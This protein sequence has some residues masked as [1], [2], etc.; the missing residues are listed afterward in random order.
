[1][2]TAPT[3]PQVT[4]R[5]RGALTRLLRHVSGSIGLFLTLVFVLMAIAG[6]WIAPYDPAAPDYFNLTAGISSEHWLGTDA[7]GRDTLSRVLAGARYSITIGLSA[8]LLGA[9]VGGAW[10]LAAGFFSGWFDTLSMRLVDVL[11]AFPGILLAIGLVTL[12]GPGVGPVVLASAIFGIPVFARLARGSTIGIKEGAYI[13]AATGLGASNNRVML[14]HVL[15]AV[16]QPVLVFAT[17]RSGSTL[18]IASGLS[19]LG[20]GIRAP[21]P[22]WGGMLNEAQLYLAVQ[23]LMAFA[24]GIAITLAV[25]GFNLLGDGLRDVLDPTLRE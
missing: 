20:L 16:I 3:A 23:P 12:T 6:P 10:G 24:P 5:R 21:T 22:E 19:F 17:L 1:M 25:L 8:T 4:G 2:S 9:L 15:P 14:K 18:L 7:F 11:L 13:E